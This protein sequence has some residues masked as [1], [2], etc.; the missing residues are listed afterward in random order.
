M[1]ET[2]IVAI[3]SRRYAVHRD[4]AK[5]P[6]GQAFGFLSD[7]A[8]DSEGNVH[9]GQ[10]TDPAML[11]FDAAGRLMRSWGKGEIIDVH[12][13]SATPD[14]RVL[15]V[16][17]DA[18][19]VL[20]HDTQGK[21]KLALGMRHAPAL[22]APFNHPTSAA[23][24]PDG[25][26][27]VSDGYGNSVVHRFGADGRIKRTWG[28]R[29]TGP[30]QFTTPHAVWIDRRG[31]VLVADRENNRVQIFDGDGTYLTEWGDFYHPM[32]I[33]GDD[34]DMIYI[35][36]Q[37]PRITMLNLEGDLVGR[38]RGTLNGA[39]GMSGDATGNFYLSELPPERVT[40]LTLLA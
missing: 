11:V 16:D 17:R 39:H 9:V 5:L 6:S 25:D 30:G 12:G 27:Y 10:R 8:V 36:D 3:G 31:R 7:V 15:V 37:I 34:R 35:T 19:Q 20:I 22:Q 40:R 14:G 26:I 28:G 24:A 32:A 18:H 38:C 2:L 13:V 21:R 23:V 33:Y 1:Q 29:G 4:W